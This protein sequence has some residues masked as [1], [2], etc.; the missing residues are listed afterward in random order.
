MKL[1]TVLPDTFEILEQS[2]NIIPLGQRLPCHPFT[3]FVVN[4]NVTTLVHRDWKDKKICLVLQ[5]SDCEGGELCLVEPGIKCRFRNGDGIIF[6][7]A[8]ISHF[9]CHYKGQRISLVFHTDRE[10]DRWNGEGERS[11]NGWIDN[12]YMRPTPP[13]I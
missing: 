11:H 6:P 3:G 9:N 8:E 4:I 7:S 13:A 5:F 12:I 1:K 2:V 10:M